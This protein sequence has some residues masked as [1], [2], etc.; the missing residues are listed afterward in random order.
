MRRTRRGFSV[1][2]L[3]VT[4]G[5][6]ALLAG[7]TVPRYVTMN[8][9]NRLDRMARSMVVDLKRTRAL[10]AAGQVISAGPPLVK[11][12]IAGIRIDS[13]TRYA[14]FLDPDDDAGNFN[15]IDVRTIDLTDTDRAG[16][17]RITS[18]GPGTQIRFERNGGTNTIDIVIADPERSR[19]RGI[20]L[21][22]GGQTRLRPI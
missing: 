21:T 16:N 12:R 19:R 11:T 6:M 7:I 17:I 1:V 18:P 22:A 2:E 4:I 15:E 9:E 5:I 20:E 10:A 8:R 13:P 3:L 14:V